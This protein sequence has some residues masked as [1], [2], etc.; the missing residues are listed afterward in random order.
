MSTPQHAVI[1]TGVDELADWCATHASQGD[2]LFLTPAGAPL[3]GYG[4][5]V[6]DDRRWWGAILRELNQY[7]KVNRGNVFVVISLD[8]VFRDDRGGDSIDSLIA[9]IRQLIEASHA[10]PVRVVLVTGDGVG[11]VRELFPALT[12]DG[13]SRPGSLQPAMAPSSSSAEQDEA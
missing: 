11:R 10:A 3:E 9:E 12:T 7:N 6:L 1:G 2:F 8:L 4:I 13:D 5:S